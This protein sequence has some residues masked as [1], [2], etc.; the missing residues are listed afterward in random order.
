MMK[1]NSTSTRPEDSSEIR[2]GAPSMTCSPVPR[3]FRPD[4]RGTR[5]RFRK[6]PERMTRLITGA[7]PVANT[8]PNI[9]MP[10]GKMKI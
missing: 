6:W 2:E 1:L 8:A 7:R 3:K 9:P 10:Q 4:R 5:V